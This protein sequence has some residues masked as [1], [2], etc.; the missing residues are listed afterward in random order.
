MK[1]S[2]ATIGSSR[3]KLPLDGIG[4]DTVKTTRYRSGKADGVDMKPREMEEEEEADDVKVYSW[5]EVALILDRCF[6]Y[7]FIAMVLIST[8]VCFGIL[9]Y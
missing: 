9:L 5:K 3:L 7:L 2:E 4:N 8:V 1:P 6:M